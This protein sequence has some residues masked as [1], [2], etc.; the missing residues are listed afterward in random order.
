MFPSVAS[1]MRASGRARRHKAFLF[2]ICVPALLPSFESGT[3]AEVVRDVTGSPVSGAKA[4]LLSL[5]RVYEVRSTSDG[6]FLFSNI[7]PGIYDLEV[8]A[9]G[10]RSQI[11][12]AV[13]IPEG[14]AQLAGISLTLASVPDHCGFVTTVNY[15]ALRPNSMVLSGH[16]VDEDS[17]KALGRVRVE[18][19][20]AASGTAVAATDSGPE[21]NFAFSDLPPGHYKVRATR[22]TYE[23]IELAAFIVPRENLTVLR[24]AIDKHGHMHICE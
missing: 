8:S 21:G 11:M 18:V 15:E 9:P 19:F 1:Y 13:R 5:D 7:V 24:F 6:A 23:P 14:D 3:L 22:K 4:R 16:V 20:G 10:F 12:T 2:L 17:G